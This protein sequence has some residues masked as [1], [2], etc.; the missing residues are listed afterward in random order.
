MAVHFGRQG[1]RAVQGGAVAL[2]DGAEYDDADV[3]RSIESS[4]ERMPES[5]RPQMRRRMEDAPVS[6]LM[7][8][9]S[10]LEIDRLGNLW[11]ETYRA[12]DY[13]APRNWSVFN[14][15]G[16]WLGEVVLTEGL[17]VYEIGEDYVLGK[18]TDEFDVEYVNVYPIR[19]DHLPGDR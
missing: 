3:S 10:A 9:H 5:R 1:L 4:L 16:R 17:E 15:D 7:P 6:P 14:A 13:V 19:K 8:S 2:S 12:H 18:E 11:V